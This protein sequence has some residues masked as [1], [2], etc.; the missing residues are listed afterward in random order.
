[1]KRIYLTG[2]DA[3]TEAIKRIKNETQSMTILKPLKPL[4]E[5]TAE[6]TYQIIQGKKVKDTSNF[7]FDG[8]TVKG[9]LFKPILIDQSNVDTNEA[10]KE[11]L[12]LTENIKTK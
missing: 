6:M 5:A 10:L 12:R 11:Q 7:A 1:M 9:K 8:V 2:Q 3:S 4:A